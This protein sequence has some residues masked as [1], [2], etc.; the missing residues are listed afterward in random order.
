VK[1]REKKIEWERGMGEWE[2]STGSKNTLS[3]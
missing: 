1:E 2:I 3:F